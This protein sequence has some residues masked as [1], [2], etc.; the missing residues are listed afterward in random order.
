MIFIECEAPIYESILTDDSEVRSQ[1]AK[2]PSYVAKNKKDMQKVE[3]QITW[4]NYCKKKFTEE[5]IFD[6]VKRISGG[7]QALHQRNIIHR[8]V[9]PSKIQYFANQG[10]NGVF[11]PT[12]HVKFNP[13]GMPFNFKKLLKRDNFSGH[14]NYSSPE[15]IL[16]KEIF[17][18]KVDVWSLGCCIYYLY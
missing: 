3:S 2:V 5:E 8:D 12:E 14:V 17:S 10:L 9:H 1:Q 18:N 4:K 16:E 11:Y 6:I 7:L 15:L 13:I